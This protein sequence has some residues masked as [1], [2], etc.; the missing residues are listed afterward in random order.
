MCY[1]STFLVCFGSKSGSIW[2]CHEYFGL[3]LCVTKAQS[4]IH[5]LTELPRCPAEVYQKGD[6]NFQE[7]VPFYLCIGLCA[8]AVTNSPETMIQVCFAMLYIILIIQS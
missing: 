7:S 2:P 4:R 3:K 6:C 5:G 8:G 1:C